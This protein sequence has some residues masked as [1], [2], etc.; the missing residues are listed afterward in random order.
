MPRAVSSL[1]L[2]EVGLTRHRV[3]TGLDSAHDEGL[4]GLQ[5]FDAFGVG[6]GYICA[7]HGLETTEVGRVL[8]HR[9]FQH[10]RAYRIDPQPARQLDGRR[11]DETVECCVDQCR[12]AAGANR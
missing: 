2:R 6:Q 3:F 12:R 4:P 11:F 8:T 10:R 5:A 1:S 7:G 9:F